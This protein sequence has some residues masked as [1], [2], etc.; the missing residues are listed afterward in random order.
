MNKNGRTGERLA[1]KIVSTE[2]RKEEK[3]KGEMR[4]KDKKEVFFT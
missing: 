1:K 2:I 4:Q 3:R